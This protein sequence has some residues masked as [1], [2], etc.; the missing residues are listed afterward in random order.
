MGEL[1]NWEDRL[2]SPPAT[3]EAD[4]CNYCGESLD[5]DGQLLEI[6]QCGDCG[7]DYCDACMDRH[8]CD[9]S[10]VPEDVDD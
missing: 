7:H 4:T 2:M 3:S 6:K 5:E 9:E 1:T 10:L 8:D